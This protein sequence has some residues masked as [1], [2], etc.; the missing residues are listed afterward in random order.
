MVS[1]TELTRQNQIE[2]VLHDEFYAGLAYTNAELLE[3][4]APAR[5]K[6]YRENPDRDSKPKQYQ[7][8]LLGDLSGK[9]VCDYACGDGADSVLLVANGAER[10]HAFDIS[11]AAVEMTKRRAKLCGIEHRVEAAR[12]NA[13]QLH[14]GTDCFDAVY[15]SAILHHL[16]IADAARELNRVIRPG[17][18]AVFREPFEQSKVLSSVIAFI[19]R[20]TPLQP[21]AV[22]PQRQLN[23]AD[24]ELLRTIFSKV[25]VKAFGIF[26]RL[27]RILKNRTLIAAINRFDAFLLKH[28]SPLRRYARCIVIECVK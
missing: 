28:F 4:S 11:D 5:L 22:T 21:D 3:A 19:F 10:V 8:F 18:R 12:G 26:N 24:V 2:Q 7:F 16:N 6:L 13:E 25:N 9:V 15:G 1:K 20:M 14:Y 27:D 17:G 23:V